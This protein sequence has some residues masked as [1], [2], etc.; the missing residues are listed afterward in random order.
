MAKNEWRLK[1]APGSPVILD[2]TSY[3]VDGV[4]NS[5]VTLRSLDGMSTRM[6][7]QQL[8]KRLA[9][10]T[11]PPPL[12]ER[13]HDVEQ[14]MSSRQ[15]AKLDERRAIVRWFEAG[16][17]PEQGP[18]ELPDP[19]HDPVLVPNR[20]TRVRAMAEV[21]A[22]RK[23]I[24]VE[25]ASKHVNRILEKATAG[26]AGLVD[27][28]LIA[29]RR[30][31]KHDE[32]EGWVRE[33][34]LDRVYQSTIAHQ[35]KYVSFVA[36]LRREH[37]ADTPSRRTFERALKNVYE[38]YPHLRL[39][40]KSLASTAQAPKVATERR[41][42]MR[43]GEY[44]FIDSTTSNVMLRDPYAPPEKSRDYRLTFTRVVDGASRHLV[45]RSVSEDVNGFAAGLAIADAFRAMVEGR[46]ALSEAGLPHQPPTI[47]LPSVLSRWPI[48]PR[49]LIADNGREFLN[50]HGMWTLHRLGI[51]VEPMRVRDGRGKAQLERYFGTNKTNFEQQQYNYIGGAVDERGRDAASEVILTWDQ[52]L[53]RDRQWA[54]LYNV[55][56]H[57][58]LW[59]ETG[60]RISPAERWI[61]LAEEHGITEM[62]AWQNEWIRFLPNQVLALNRYGVDRKGMIYNA[63][64]IRT[65]IDVDGAAPSGNVRIFW[66]PN[67]LRQVYCFDPAGNAYEVPWVHRT[68]DTQPFTDF[69]LSWAR[70]RLDGTTRSKKEHQKHLIDLVAHWQSE[71]VVLLAQLRGRK[72]AEEILASQLHAIRNAD[73]GSI[74]R[75]ENF[76]GQ[77]VIDAMQAGD[78]GLALDEEGVELL[79]DV[80]DLFGEFD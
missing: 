34:M 16:L 79:E 42:A 15:A 47:G 23:K 10:D 14:R 39:K 76:I 36:W 4:V 25:S 56:E 31:R 70:G 40:T 68:E 50:K 2:G 32:I 64:I 67:D 75:A 54:E 57:R 61:E 45:G 73:V 48:P 37:E 78:D 8:G 13:I 33:F 24:K 9:R 21:I 62:V 49:R 43:V 28:R 66:D 60:R 35:S 5:W 3:M 52:L 51:D 58:G 29:P 11:A 7:L 65:L 6:P 44:W 1:I 41:F 63:P 69:T 46:D 12:S 71:D 20:R 55:T 27:P 53:E 30:V 77:E 17:R 19:R 74:I 80:D 72:N 59:S 18:G 38:R 22:A 26:E